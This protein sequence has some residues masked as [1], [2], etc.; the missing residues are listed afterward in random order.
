MKKRPFIYLI[1]SIV[2]FSFCMQQ[3]KENPNLPYPPVPKSWLSEQLKKSQNLSTSEQFK[4]IEKELVLLKNDAQVLPLGKLD[5]KIALLSIGGN[6]SEFKETISLFAQTTNF[7]FHNAE[8]IPDSIYSQMEQ[9]DLCLISFHADSTESLTINKQQH[10]VLEKLPKNLEKI[11]V[12]FGEGEI[13]KSNI[14]SNCKAILWGRENH[15]MAQN[16]AAQLLFGAIGTKA[17]LDHDLGHLY[18]TGHG[19]ITVP[20]GRL[21]FGT[22]EEL[23]IDPNKLKRID[24]IALK[25]IKDGAYPGCQIAVA[26]KGQF[27]YRKSFGA[28]TYL[29]S[30]IKINNEAV[31]DIASISK[32]AGSTLLAMHL[33][34][35]GLYSLDKKLKDYIP[36]LT[37]ET[38][39]SNIGL[40]EMM[41]HQSG[42][43][44]WIAFY[45]KTLKNGQLSPSIYAKKAGNGYELEVAENIYMRTDYVDSM[46]QQILATPLGAKKYEYSDLCYYFTQK[47]FE[48][49]IGKKQNTYLTEMIYAPMG[50][51]YLRYLPRSCFPLTQIVPTE[52]DQAFRKQLI[53]GYVHDP[54]AAMLGGVG[55]HA[56][57][58]SN[59]TDLASIMQL[60]LKHGK[61]G[62]QTYF[63]EAIMQE[64]TKAQFAGNRRG[65]G[66]DRPNA[67]GG[68]TCDEL[69]SS[70]SFGHSGFTGTLAWADPKDE[71]VFIFLSNRVHP[72]QDNWKLRDLG[73][74]TQ[75]QHV[76]YEAVNSRKK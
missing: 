34:Y 76:V 52:R 22:P 4:A 39:Y 9:F 71:V 7:T 61:Y 38:S 43:T 47:I 8:Q 19:L 63:N 40:R 27:I 49:L 29:D 6:S 65:A 37:K 75:L 68:G 57:I 59:A 64:Y 11:S 20:N 24:E 60:I 18:K 36:E 25:G 54:G 1:L 70:L 15:W 48:K 45:K 23:G 31:Y 17:T 30:S 69:A 14:H 51:R 44:P 5:R 55:G 46:Y 42:L 28:Q 10:T 26:V 74:R 50:L 32:I 2:L 62:G 21:K 58:F 56:G 33:Q 13:F 41:A 72:N 67:S 66:F 73:I 12:I 3:W 53:H 16:R 35:K